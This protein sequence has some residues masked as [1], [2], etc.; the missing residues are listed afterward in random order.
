M[1]QI[2]RS[3][4]PDLDDAQYGTMMQ[5][6]RKHKEKQRHRDRDC[7]ERSYPAREQQRQKQQKYRAGWQKQQLVLLTAPAP[8]PAPAPR[9]PW[10]SV[11]TSEVPA[12]V[13]DEPLPEN[14][15]VWWLRLQR[16]GFVHCGWQHVNH[17]YRDRSSVRTRT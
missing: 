11:W 9:L 8:A 13:M 10:T 7:T 3:D 6:R 17:P 15:D 14:P 12:L 4:F 5:Q 1:A 16:H 2:W